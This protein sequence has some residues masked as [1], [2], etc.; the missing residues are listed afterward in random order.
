M[1]LTGWDILMI[2]IKK[3]NEINIIPVLMVVEHMPIG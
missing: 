2:L 1:M 3:L